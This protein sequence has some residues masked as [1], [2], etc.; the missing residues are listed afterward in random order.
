[1]EEKLQ[2]KTTAPKPKEKRLHKMGKDT[3]GDYIIIA[4]LIIFAFVA[5]FPIW[6][7]IVGSLNNGSDYERG[8]VIFWPRVF[9]FANYSAI[10][11]DERIWQGL[12]ISVLRVLTGPILSVLFT[13]FV[14]YG[15]GRKELHFKKAFNF[16]NL[17]TMFF[18]GGMIPYYLL[19]RSI[20]LLNTF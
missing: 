6:Y 11:A 2:G 13:S 17:F 4:F 15:M 19:C 12:L 5:F 1:M 16:L 9:T 3:V 10:V 20:G 14:A 8:G 18:A 7:T